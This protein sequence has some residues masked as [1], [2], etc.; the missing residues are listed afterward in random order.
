MSWVWVIVLFLERRRLANAMCECDMSSRPQR[1][2][3]VDAQRAP[4]GHD[5]SSLNIAAFAPI[6]GASVNTTV[7]VNPGR[8]HSVLR[9]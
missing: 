1:D 9:A 8:S 5:R 7:S 2:H 6:P 3:R 4:R